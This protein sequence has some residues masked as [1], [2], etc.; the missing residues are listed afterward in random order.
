MMETSFLLILFGLTGLFALV[1]ES[2]RLRQLRIAAATDEHVA[3]IRAVRGAHRPAR[4][5]R[6]LAPQLSLFETEE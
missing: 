4:A 2:R 3:A 6:R 5:E 1:W